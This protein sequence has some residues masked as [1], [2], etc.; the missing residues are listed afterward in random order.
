MEFVL[1]RAETTRK[2]GP[3]KNDFGNSAEIPVANDRGC[4]LTAAAYR[5]HTHA[6]TH[7]QNDCAR[8]RRRYDDRCNVVYWAGS[9]NVGR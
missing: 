7:A 8:R 1:G 6:L 2:T 9:R 4:V 3:A 5:L